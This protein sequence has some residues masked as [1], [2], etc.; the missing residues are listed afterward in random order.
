MDNL[1]P[2]QVNEILVQGGHRVSHLVYERASLEHDFFGATREPE[3]AS[4]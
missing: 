2:T 1:N 3:G 4:L